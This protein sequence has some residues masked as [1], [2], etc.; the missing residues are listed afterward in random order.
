MDLQVF[1]WIS[2]GPASLQYY[3]MISVLCRLTTICFCD[4]HRH[5][6]KAFLFCPSYKYKYNTMIQQLSIIHFRVAETIDRP[7]AAAAVGVV[8]VAKVVVI[9]LVVVHTGY[10]M[11]MVK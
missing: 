5:C 6:M 1:I 11:C 3:N 2:N 7:A 4:V 10:R 8:L 9:V